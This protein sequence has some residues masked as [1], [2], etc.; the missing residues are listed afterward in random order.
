MLIINTGDGKGKTTSAFGLALRSLSLNK[1]VL[2][3]QF[4]KPKK[5]SSV[6]LLE[7][8]FP[9]LKALNFGTD[10]FIKKGEL[11]K[12]LVKQCAVGFETLQHI[13]QDYDLII[14]DEVFPSLY[15]GLLDSDDVFEFVQ[16]IKSDKD[17]VLTGRKC[18]QRFV[19]L[20]DIVTEMKNIKHHYNKGTPAKEGI[21]Y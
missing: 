20:A 8:Q 21:D 17:V 6:L 15:F 10:K 5:E 13:W 12:E 1:K 14:I 9:N 18:P 7:K 4:M 3:F 16:K 2:L 11:P 19:E